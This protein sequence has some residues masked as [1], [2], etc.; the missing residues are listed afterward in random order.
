MMLN[1]W[2]ASLSLCLVMPI[3]E[4]LDLG[5]LPA[6]SA[7]PVDPIPATTGSP[8]P[9]ALPGQPATL[10]PRFEVSVVE[11]LIDAPTDG[12]LVVILARR[13]RPEPRNAI[14]LP[15]PGSPIVLGVDA[16]LVAPG[17]V[18]VVDASAR[19]FPVAALENLPPGTYVAQAVLMRNPDL[20]LLNAPGNLSSAPTPVQLDPADTEPIPLELARIDPP[21]RLPDDTDLVRYLKVPSKLLSEFHGRPMFLRVAVVLPRDYGKDPSVRYPLRVHIGGFGS[22]FTAARRRMAEGS[23]FRRMWL[24]DDTPRFVMLFLDGAGPLGDP[25]Q[26][27][28]ANHGPYGDAITQELIP[29]V[30]RLYRGIGQGY[31][32]VLDGGSTG[33]W[34]SIALQVF[35]PDFF[36]GCWASCPDSLDFRSFQLL[37]I[38]DDANAYTTADGAERPA[39][40][41]EDGTP[42]YSMRDECGLE[43]A[44]GLG[45]SWSMSGGQWGSWNATYSP[46]GPDGRPVPLWDPVTGA[47][48]TSVLDHWSQYDIRRVLESD[49]QTLGPKLRGK[50]HIWMGDADN[51]FLEQAL[52]RL[53]AFLEAADPP[54]EGSIVYGAGEGHCW[55]GITELEMMQQMAEAVASGAPGQ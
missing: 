42:V 17:T 47:I 40:R 8:E 52:R 14:S 3:V 34:V 38:Y 20:L 13:A 30:E 29:Y 54:F 23:P 19:S 32:R 12:R 4:A 39:F 16:E 51:F 1:R 26:V 5:S 43:N 27:N 45:G 41:R 49:W 44:L 36:N 48:D 10:A 24:A 11:G 22:R 21:E 15:V 28:S 35:Y 33:G 2:L 18:T 25:Y 53:E 37:N 7:E 50:L 31:A 6:R 55:S 9:A 46:R